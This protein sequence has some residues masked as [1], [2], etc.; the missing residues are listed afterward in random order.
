V[1]GDIGTTTAPTEAT[2]ELEARLTRQ[3][4]ARLHIEI[5]APDTELF[6]SGLIDSLAF[7]ELLLIVS[8]EFG[9]EADIAD[10]EMDNFRTVRRIA[11][12]VAERRVPEDIKPE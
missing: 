10:L 2:A 11:A 6:E 7:V 5:A 9:V 12:F 1:T 4:A 3:M 8:E